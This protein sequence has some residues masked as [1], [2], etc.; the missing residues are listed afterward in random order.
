MERIIL[1][2]LIGVNNY[3]G[4]NEINVNDRD[5]KEQKNLLIRSK[6]QLVAKYKY[7]N[8]ENVKTNTKFKIN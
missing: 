6:D 2:S 5:T 8:N 3:Y 1:N 7:I 4:K